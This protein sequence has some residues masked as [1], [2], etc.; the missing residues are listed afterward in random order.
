VGNDDE[1]GFIMVHVAMDS[2]TGRLVGA[3][4]QIL[5]AAKAKDRAKFVKGFREL[6]DAVKVI[7]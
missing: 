1:N 6:N 2:Y 5:A 4:E 7:N 3:A